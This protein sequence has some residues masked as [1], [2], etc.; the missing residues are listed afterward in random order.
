MRHDAVGIARTDLHVGQDFSARLRRAR[1]PSSFACSAITDTCANPPSRGTHTRARGPPSSS[2]GGPA[3]RCSTSGPSCRRRTPRPRPRRPPCIFCRRGIVPRCRRG[4]FS[5]TSACGR[6]ASGTAGGA[7]CED[8][9]A[10]VWRPRGGVVFFFDLAK[11][12]PRV[13]KRDIYTG[14]SVFRAT[15]AWRRFTPSARPGFH[16]SRR[17][18]RP[19]ARS[20][21]ARSRATAATRGAADFRSHGASAAGA[22]AGVGRPAQK[23]RERHR[24][25]RRGARRPRAAR[26]RRRRLGGRQQRA[27]IGRGRRRGRGAPRRPRR[28]GGT[29]HGVH[30]R[31]RRRAQPPPAERRRRGSGV[32][33]GTGSGAAARRSG[34]TWR[35]RRSSASSR[36]EDAAGDDARG[37]V[38][39]SRRPAPGRARGPVFERGE[40]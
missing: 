6:G 34:A 3:C 24:R 1:S 28:L 23:G 14:N 30:L 38:S 31:L 7:S 17:A 22:G 9:F 5:Y 36:G 37:V 15:P 2:N 21:S 10:L 40:K 26:A 35:K 25:R 16:R 19:R 8:H 29:R 20:R 32:D 4:V 11:K 33:A 18:L 13:Y 12:V 39:R 27:E